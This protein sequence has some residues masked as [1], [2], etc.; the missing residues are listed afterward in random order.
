MPRRT[1][2]EPG[3]LPPAASLPGVGLVPVVSATPTEVGPSVRF[4]ITPEMTG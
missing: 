2:R 4:D 3:A 1:R